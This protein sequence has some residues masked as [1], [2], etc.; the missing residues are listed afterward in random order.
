MTLTW[1][2]FLAYFQ[3]VPFFGIYILMFKDIFKTAFNFLII[4]FIFL[5]GFGLGF[6]ILFIN[7]V[8]I[9]INTN[10]VGLKHC[11]PSFQLAFDT[12]SWA[13][14]KTYVMMIGEFEFEGMFTEHDDP[15]KNNAEN[16]EAAKQ[17]PFPQYSTFLFVVFVFVMSIIVSNLLVGLAVDDIKEIQDHAEREKLSMH[18]RL[19]L[20]SERFLPHLKCCLSNNFLFHYMQPKEIITFEKPNCFKVRDVLS[21]S[22]LLEYLRQ[23]SQGPDRENAVDDILDKQLEMERTLKSLT[24][25]VKYLIEENQKLSDMIAKT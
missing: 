19:V 2:N 10:N 24:S 8:S 21:K 22:M 12:P 20:E 7:H 16:A 18:V 13:I 5:I 14:A 17:I 9:L 15:D 25:S 23:R 4:L 6:H 11:F 1:L 3:H